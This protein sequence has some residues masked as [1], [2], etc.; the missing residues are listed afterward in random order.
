MIISL[1]C[2]S[3]FYAAYASQA[4]AINEIVDKAIE[5]SAKRMGGVITAIYS[6]AD[7]YTEERLAA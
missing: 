7:T 3:P 1:E 4:D 5:E 2:D 6:I